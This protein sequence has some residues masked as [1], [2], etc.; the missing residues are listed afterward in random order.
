MKHVY[1]IA[2]A[3][4]IAASLFSSTA[5]SAADYFFS[6][7]GAKS[8]SGTI[9]TSD[10]MNAAGGFD[11]TNITGSFDGFDI[12]GLFTGTNANFAYDNILFPNNS[13]AFL[14]GDGLAFTIAGDS[15]NI[16]SSAMLGMGYGGST[17]PNT[18]YGLVSGSE[19]QGNFTL[20]NFELNAA[21]VPEPTTWMMMLLG[22]G[23]MG[24]AMRRQ[25][26]TIALA[27]IA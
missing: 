24:F 22:F 2:M 10:T 16:Y 21:G 18:P 3:A 25:R 15:G 5:A 9:T 23:G 12:T 7:T 14:S 13:A 8:A 27:Q 17:D 26:K 1:K 4:G 20:G 19:A 6:Y 11:I